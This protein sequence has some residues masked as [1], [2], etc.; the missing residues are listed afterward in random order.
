MKCPICGLHV[1]ASFLAFLCP[2]CGVPLDIEIVEAAGWRIEGLRG[3]WRYRPLIPVA[4][5]A[6]PV[7]LGEGSTPLISLRATPPLAPPPTRRG[8]G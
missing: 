5:D 1:D 6:E 7:T 3:V 2:R 4:G 8:L